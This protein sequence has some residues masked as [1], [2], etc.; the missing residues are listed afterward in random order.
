[1]SKNQPSSGSLA[2]LDL[3]ACCIDEY[4]EERR[5]DAAKQQETREIS[6]RA[7]DWRAS[8]TVILHCAFI[9]RLRCKDIAGLA[10]PEARRIVEVLRLDNFDC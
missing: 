9:L 5:K 10:S 6:H 1:M 8:N 2:F 4:A 3:E 7:V